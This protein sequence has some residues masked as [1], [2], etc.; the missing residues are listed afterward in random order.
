MTREELREHCK[1]QIKMC[2][3]WAEARG[4]NPCGEIYEEH[5]LILELLEQ[6]SWGDVTTVKHYWEG[7]N[8]GIQI[9]NFKESKQQKSC[10]DAVSRQ[11]ILNKIK[12][13]CFS[14]EWIQFRVDKG[15]NG[16][17]DFLINYIKQLPSTT[18]HP[19]I[20]RWIEH[21]HETGENWEYPMYECSECHT[22]SDDDSNY[23]PNCGTKMEEYKI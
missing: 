1:K 19:K 3:V 13:V 6:E 4:E 22:W 9:E 12:E 16:Q 15:S 10:N 18:S 2:E 20:G 21:P 7:S 23:C 8:D 17:R 11:A 5:K 14:K